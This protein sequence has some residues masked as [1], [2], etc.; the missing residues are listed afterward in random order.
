MSA[1]EG[2]GSWRE[3]ARRIVDDVHTPGGRRFA[4]A[5]QGLILLSVLSISLDT[6]QGLPQWLRRLLHGIDLVIIM[7]FT[8]EYALRIWAARRPLSYVLSFWGLV[9]LAAVAPFW[10]VGA[11]ARAVRAFRLLRI[12]HIFR[13]GEYARALEHFA[14]AWRVVRKDV[15]MFLGMAAIAMYLA[16]L[17]IWH[18]EHGAQPAAFG[19]IFDA[20]WWAMITLTTVGYGDI[21]PVTTGG[22]IFTMLLLVVGLG[23]VAVPSGLLATAFT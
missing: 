21:Y 9:D 4:L 7:F 10:I 18:F 8:V 13:F 12:V 17:G 16:A 19:S 5:V 15:Q 23:L 20:L 14:H 6:F 1:N 2:A 11:D 3:A 22:R